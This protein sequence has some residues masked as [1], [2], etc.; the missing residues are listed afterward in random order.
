MN[1]IAAKLAGDAP[2][3]DFENN[4]VEFETDFLEFVNDTDPKFDA[5]LL[6]Y[7]LTQ[8]LP[9]T[10]ALRL[11]DSIY[12]KTKKDLN[13][14]FKV[15]KGKQVAGD[16]W[17]NQVVIEDNATI[18]GSLYS[19]K[20]MV[21]GENCSIGGSIVAGGRL[22]VRNGCQIGGALVA[23]EIVLHGNIR[24]DGTIYSRGDLLSRGSLEAQELLAGGNIQ[25]TGQDADEIIVEAA[26]IF[27]QNGEIEVNVPIKLGLSQR[28]V[29]LLLQKFYLSRSGDGTFRLARTPAASPGGTRTGQGALITNLSDAE[30]EKLLADLAT[31]ER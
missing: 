4:I 14:L 30:L 20:D 29:N 22:E 8:Q 10:M 13:Q 1:P 5:N 6:R 24:A 25:L 12:P 19:V 17:G 15:E 28:T 3:P 31:A 11:D 18:D 9:E 2:L 26:T 16:I 23:G 21:L 27:A 7:P